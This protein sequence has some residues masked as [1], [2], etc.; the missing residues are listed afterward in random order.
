MV[1][2]SGANGHYNGTRPPDSVLGPALHDYSKRTLLL[3]QRLA[4]LTKD[5]GYT[6]GLTTLK[7]LNREFK[8]KTVK[9]PPPDH[10]SATLVAE[11][12]MNNVS[13]RNGPRTIQTQISLQHGVKIP[14]DT[15][16]RV[17]LDLDP[18][19]AE[20]RFPGCRRQPKQRG[21]LTDTGV[22]YELHFDGHEKLNFKA[23]RMGPVGIDIYGARCHSSSKMVK[24]L[25]VPNARCSSTVGHYYLD[26][27]EQHG[28]FVQATVDGG[29]ETGELYAAHVA[30]RQQCMPD[31]TV[32]DAPAFVALK[33]TDNIPIESS[34]HLFTNYVG[35]DIK[36]I[37]LLGK[38][39]NYFH[40]SFQLHIDLFNWLWPK[41]VQLSLDEFVEYWNNHKI[42][43]QRNKLL[44]SG[45][46][47]NY[48]CDFPESFGLVDFSVPA[49]QDF[50]DALRQNIP[51]PR[52]E[53]YRW[54]SD[55]FDARAWEVYEHIGAPKLMLTEGWTIFCQMLPHFC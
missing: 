46:S 8:V 23:L 30:L 39:L 6:I 54:V 18:D 38:S 47:P 41:I 44:P 33:S 16:R 52:D 17:M 34:W 35:L 4:Y 32:E 43:T 15:V 31:I 21:H 13:S 45:F 37:I 53:C 51:K 9:K 42:R 19:G 3:N 1:N 10:I 55:E 5:F 11:V 36:Q 50:V 49:P 20:A 22:F 40:P 24:F 2:Q 27:V 28:V 29:S 48:I 12:M 14:R 26:L 7:K 25:V